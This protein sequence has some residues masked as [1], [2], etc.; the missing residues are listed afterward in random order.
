AVAVLAFVLFLLLPLDFAAVRISQRLPL[1]EQLL[2]A[3]YQQFG[4]FMAAHDLSAPTISIKSVLTPDRLRE[5]TRIVL[6]EAGAIISSGVLI[7]FLAF[8]FVAA[9]VEDTGVTRG[10]LAEKLAYYGSAARSY[11]MVTAKSAS[12]NAVLN[13]IF[14]SVMGVDT[15]V[16][17]AAVY[18][19]LDFIPT[20]G[21]IAALLPPTFVTLLMYGWK[22]ALVVAIG[23]VL[24]N[25]LIDNLVTPIFMK[26]A[27]DV[28]LLEITLSLMGWTFLLGVPG[29]ILAIPLT[30]ALKKFIDKELREEAVAVEPAAV[31][32]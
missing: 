5:A 18:F 17:W 7:S 25:L 12:I 3:R 2:S 24:T 28:S 29:A 6:P 1:Y 30:L 11:V 9:M 21:F 23:L 8:L 13:L 26:H 31:P 16:L 20:V 27:V 10:P 19:V 22:R 4:G 14:L 15:P 32:L